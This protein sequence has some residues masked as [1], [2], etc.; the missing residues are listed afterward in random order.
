MTLLET[1][2]PALATEPASLPAPAVFLQ[3]LLGKHITYSLSAIA[4]MGVADHMDT[5]PVQ[6]DELARKTGAN[7]PSL[8]RVMRMLASVGVF[9]EVPE[10]SFRLTPVGQLLK[11]D[12]PGSL[13]YSAIQFGDQWST[14]PWEHFTETVRTGENG[15]R[16]AYGKDIFELFVDLPEQAEVF[17]RSMTNISA[18]MVEPIASA[19]DF[20]SIDRLADVGGGH[21]MLLASI[22]T[23]HPHMQGVLYDLPEVV[24][25]AGAKPHLAGCEARVRIESGS[26]FEHVPSGCDA[27]IM[28]FI[29]HDW[30]DDH[31]RQILSATRK[32]FPTNGRILVC[33]QIVADGPGLAKLVDIEMLAMTVGGKERTLAEFSDLFSSAGLRLTEVFRTESPLCILEARSA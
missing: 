26:F 4:R 21:G 9:E 33:E 24:A 10:K 30:S 3:L 5:A 19:Y 16:K 32:E 13:R 12:A 22:L 1:E 11:T 27:Y 31:C 6:I 18:A 20:S 17:N 25:S 29:L 8:Y 2:D 23:R 14:R 15:V 28:K 7:P